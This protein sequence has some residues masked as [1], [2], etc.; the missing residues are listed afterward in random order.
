MG[1]MRENVT[2]HVWGCQVLLMWTGW[3]KPWGVCGGEHTPP[4]TQSNPNHAPH[5]WCQELQ[6]TMHINPTYLIVHVPSHAIVQSPHMCAN[7]ANKSQCTVECKMNGAV[8]VLSSTTHQKS[9]C[10]A[11]SEWLP[12]L[13]R[14][15]RCV[16]V[17]EWCVAP[18]LRVSGETDDVRIGFFG[19]LRVSFFSVFW[20]WLPTAHHCLVS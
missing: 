9:A 3:L 7:N 20:T 8:I 6:C 16:A 1:R 10:T 14:I 11:N 4:H 2:W 12:G 18:T 17:L 5:E 15:F 19:I 13:D